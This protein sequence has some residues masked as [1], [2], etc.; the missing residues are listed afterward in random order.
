MASSDLGGGQNGHPRKLFELTISLG[1]V[2]QIIA[3][4]FGG[5]AVYSDLK[6][7]QAV[8]TARMAEQRE[9]ND[10]RFKALYLDFERLRQESVDALAE[11]KIDIR[12]IREA[13]SKRSD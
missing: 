6:S 10:F 5:A 9:Y 1:Q 12:S 8:L 4:L 11:I 7:E 3:L 2:L 13:L